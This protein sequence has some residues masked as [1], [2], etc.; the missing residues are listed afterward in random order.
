[1]AAK[2]SKKASTQFKQYVADQRQG[3]TLTDWYKRLAQTANKRLERAEKYQQQEYFKPAAK[4]AYAVAQHDIKA[5]RGEHATRFAGKATGTESQIRSQINA[6]KKYLAS[7]TST[8]Q[9][10]ISVY[11]KRAE[12]FNKRYGTNFT[13]EQL[14]KYFESGE[15]KKWE[16]KFG[17]KTALKTI[18][19]LQ[20]NKKEVLKSIEENTERDI[21]VD[22]NILQKTVSAALADNNLDIVSLFA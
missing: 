1:M 20:K 21:R 4:W 9:G 18:G 19:E 2:K 8:K 12:T 15:A 14:A 3:E 5:F 22:N 11:K 7:P 10:I 16:E 13:W 6:M 17:S